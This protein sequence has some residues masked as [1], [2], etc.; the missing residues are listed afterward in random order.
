MG[1]FIQYLCIYN[2]T[3][4]YIYIFNIIYSLD[5][6]WI[7]LYSPEAMWVYCRILTD[8]RI[9]W[10]YIKRLGHLGSRH[11][12]LA[13]Q[14]VGIW[15]R[16]VPRLSLKIPG[17]PLNHVCWFQVVSFPEKRQGT[18][19]AEKQTLEIHSVVWIS[20]YLNSVAL[21]TRPKSKTYF[22]GETHETNKIRVCLK[23]G[24]PI[25]STC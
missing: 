11:G 21:I 9:D 17:Q 18:E 24:Y 13:R 4:I 1:S 3:Y 5:I 23:I 19:D 15:E 6:H 10:D 8:W 16:L 14:S 22:M 2:Y 12:L 20:L 7:K 25:P